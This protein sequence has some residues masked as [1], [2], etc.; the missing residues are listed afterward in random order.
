[1]CIILIAVA[2]KKPSGAHETLNMTYN[3]YI[4]MLPILSKHV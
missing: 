1:M 4:H 2:L 3:C